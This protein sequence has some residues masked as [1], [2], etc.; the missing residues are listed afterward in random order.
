MIVVGIDPGID[1]AIARLC[2]GLTEEGVSLFRMPTRDVSESRREVDC[3]ELLVLLDEVDLVVIEDVGT[4]P[5][6]GVQRAFNFG[7]VFGQA[8]SVIELSRLP[9]LRVK[10]QQWKASMLSGT[11]KSK[12]A[13]VAK[14]NQLYP[15]LNLTK[16]DHDCAE[17]LLMAMHGRKEFGK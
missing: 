16:N 7:K 10:P 6:F 8:L 11:D 15:E 5:K 2:D 3:R 1:G 17:A 9:H 14:V 12:E 13:A 4:N